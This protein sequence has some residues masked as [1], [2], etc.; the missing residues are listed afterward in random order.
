MALAARQ[1]TLTDFESEIRQPGGAT[2][3]I[4]ENVRVAL[5]YVAR[6]EAPLGIVYET[7]A[8]AEPRGSKSLRVLQGKP[9]DVLG[10]MRQCRDQ[11][12]ASKSEVA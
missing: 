6:G 3:W 7:D 1:D 4:S 9:A 11:K 8:K 12:L 5:E 2:R 10:W